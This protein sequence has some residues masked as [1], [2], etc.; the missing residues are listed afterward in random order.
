VGRRRRWKAAGRSKKDAEKLLTRHLSELHQGVFRD[1]KAT[2]FS[3]FADQWLQDFAATR[4]K[5]S[6]H[7]SYKGLLEYHL[8][9][10]FKNYLLSQIEARDIQ[11]FVSSKA[12]CKDEDH[13]LSGRSVNYLL[14]VLKM[15]FKCAKQWRLLRENPAEGISRVRQEQQEMDFLRPNEIVALLK[16]S[17]EPYRTLFLT[18][19]LTGMRRGELLGLQW[20]DINWIDNLIYV[21]RSLYWR[22]RSETENDSPRWHFSSPKS[23]KSIRTIVMSP[24]LREALQIHRINGAISPQDLV[25]C[26]SEGT[27]MDPDNMVKQQFQPALTFAELR[28]IRFHDLRHTYTTL[29]IAQG[30]HAKFI[31]S[32]L[33]HASIQTTLDRYGHLMPQMHIGVGE[34]LDHQIFSA[35]L[36]EV[37]V[38][39]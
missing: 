12:N 35:T 21:R 37:P 25:F 39:G 15:M 34:K 23:V 1:I 18:A 17:E 6:T 14:M 28:R 38:S 30:A 22:L 33:G 9:P 4:V 3:E 31:Q 16:H 24:K 2:G 27:P 32:Q 20:G 11:R 8:K 26:S 19:I 13:K 5:I 7:R 36:N 10:F 29:L